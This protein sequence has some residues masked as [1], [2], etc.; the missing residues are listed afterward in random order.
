MT[1]RNE[2]LPTGRKVILEVP[3]LAA[4]SK[5]GDVCEMLKACSII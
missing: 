3:T 5:F 4:L 2:E 1:V